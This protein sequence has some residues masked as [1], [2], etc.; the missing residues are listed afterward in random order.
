MS[1]VF[2]DLDGTLLEYD[3]EYPAVLSAAFREVRGEV[4][5]AW[6]ETYDEAFF[7]AFERCEPEPYRRAFAAVGR[8]HPASG[9]DRDAA[10]LVEAL[11]EREI[12]ACEP[13]A[14]A[15]DALERLSETH[16]LGV[17]TNGLPE[18]QRAKLEAHDLAEHF[19]AVVASYEV[20]AHKPDPEP[21]RVAERR[22]P[23]DAYAMVGDAAADV[24]GAEAAGW[25]AHRYEGGGFADLPAALER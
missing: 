24:E 16:T 21:Y 12:A 17:L 5:E 18:W 4:R 14:S 8:A 22:L 1:A 11:R 23:A 13:P 6:L 9:A 7:E 19:E 3:R 2:F 10:A 15:V 20:G 25:R